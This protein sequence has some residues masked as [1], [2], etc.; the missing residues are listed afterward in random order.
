MIMWQRPE[1]FDKAIGMGSTGPL[2][3]WLAGQFVKLDDQRTPLAKNKFNKMLE[4]RVKLFQRSYQ[5]ED[6]GLAGLQTLLRL[7]EA[8][9]REVP[10]RALTPTNEPLSAM[11]H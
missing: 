1:A 10:L 2:V 11:E 5:L 4:R 8:L 3:D 6:D 9:G 7:G